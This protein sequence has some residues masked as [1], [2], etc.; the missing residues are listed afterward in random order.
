LFFS[1]FFICF[2]QAVKAGGTVYLSGCVGIDPAT[3]KIV[4]G[5]IGAQT[6]RTLENL[7]AVVEASGSSMEK[8]MKCTVL[9]TDMANFAEVNGIYA[10]YFHTDPPARTT[11]A[12]SGLPL[13]SLIEIDAIAIE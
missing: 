7:K 1:P 8:I 4:D 5:G 12:V 2:L 3:R 13:G 9:L 11:Y 6:R 10:E